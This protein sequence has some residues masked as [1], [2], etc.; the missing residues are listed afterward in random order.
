MFDSRA[1]ATELLDRPDCDPTL[2]AA[3]YRFMEMVNRRFGGLVAVDVDH[4][5]VQRGAI[6]GLIGPNGAGKT[7]LFNLLTGFD[8]P[9]GG[10]AYCLTLFHSLP[11]GC[12]PRSVGSFRKAGSGR[13]A[14]GAGGR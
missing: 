5:E 2:A 14:S 6:T 12:G 1:T 11:R 13:M 8:A 4:L 3:S 9:N 7:T 10:T